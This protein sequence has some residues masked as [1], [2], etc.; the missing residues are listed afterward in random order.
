MTDEVLTSVTNGPLA[1]ATSKQVI[2]DSKDWSRAEMFRQQDPI[3]EKIITSKD[4]REGATAFA[5][6]RE[7]N[8]QGC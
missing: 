7:P 1:V 8:W 6:K 2:R 4:A 5:E 3:L